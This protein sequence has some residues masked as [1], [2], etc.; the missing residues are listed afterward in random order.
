MAAKTIRVRAIYK[1][2]NFSLG[3]R[4]NVEYLLDV[5]HSKS[6]DVIHIEGQPL[7]HVAPCEYDTLLSYLNNWDCIRKA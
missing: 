1:G 2:K 6:G 5:R 7:D 4:E 3:Y